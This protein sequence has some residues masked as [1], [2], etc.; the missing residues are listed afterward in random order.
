VEKELNIV[1]QVNGK[2]RDQVTVS[3]DA[4]ENDIKKL[5][6]ESEKIKKYIPSVDN[7]RKIIFVPGRLIN[8]VV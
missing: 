2:V 4:K 8:F 1:V 6:F 3:A 7:I 5:A